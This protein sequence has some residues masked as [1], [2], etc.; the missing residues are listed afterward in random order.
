MVLLTELSGFACSVDDLELLLKELDI[1]VLLWVGLL[2]EFLEVV[3]IGVSGH[4]SRGKTSHENLG[5]LSVSLFDDFREYLIILLEVGLNKIELLIT[6]PEAT[7]L[8]LRYQNGILRIHICELIPKL[9]LQLSSW[10]RVIA[11]RLDLMSF[12]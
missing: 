10:N 2:Q 7:K 8:L 11:S 1:E 12:I 6:I 5:E 3:L 4:E 9:R